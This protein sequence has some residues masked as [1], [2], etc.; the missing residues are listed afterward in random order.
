M[1]QKKIYR[2]SSKGIIGGVC[3]G[4]AK[5]LDADP[6][7]VRLIWALGTLLWGVGIFAYLLAWIILPDEN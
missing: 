2:N 5:Y 3:Y 7:I 6:T 1:V 4:I